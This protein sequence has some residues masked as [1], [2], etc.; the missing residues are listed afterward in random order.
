M[1][2]GSVQRGGVKD[3]MSGGL[4]GH[5]VSQAR[6]HSSR[7]SRTCSL[8]GLVAIVLVGVSLIASSLSVLRLGQSGLGPLKDSAPARSL[9]VHGVISI[10]GD[11]DFGSQASA[12]GWPGNG[13]LNN[14]Y[15][16]SGYDIDGLGYL[17][18]IRI[19][20]TT[21]YF[22]VRDCHLFNGM[23]GVFLYGV[24]N[25]MLA[26]NTCNDNLLYGIDGYNSAD[27][28]LR[29]NTCYSNHVGGIYLFFSDRNTVQDNFCYNNGWRSYDVFGMWCYGSNNTVSYNYCHHHNG[30]GITIQ[31]RGSVAL[32]NTCENNSEGIHAGVQSTA[33]NNNCRDNYV[34][35]QVWESTSLFN[36]C[37]N[38]RNGIELDGWYNTVEANICSDNTYNGIHSGPNVM[39]SVLGNN[40]CVANGVAGIFV[41]G[42]N[43]HPCLYNTLIGNDCSENGQ[44]GILMQWGSHNVLANNTCDNNTQIGL[45]IL[46]CTDEVVRGNIMHGDGVFV[47]G[48]L[49]QHWVLNSIDE[50]NLVNGIPV[51]FAKDVN[52]SAIPA[53]KGQYIIANSR[54]LD[55]SGLDVRNVSA[56]ISLGFCSSSTFRDCTSSNNTLYGIYISHCDRVVIMNSTFSDNTEHLPDYTLSGVYLDY[57]YGCTIA[58]NS[59]SRNDIGVTLEVSPSNVIANNTITHN[60]YVGMQFAVQSDYNEIRGN[61]FENNSGYAVRIP[62]ILHFPL[63]VGN[64]FHDNVFWYNNGATQVYDSSHIQ[65]YDFHGQYNH[66]NGSGR[67]NLWSDWQGPDSNGD[68][69]VD[70]PYVIV[71]YSTG[72]DYYPIAGAAG[73]EP[74]PEFPLA[75]PAIILVVVVVV[76]ASKGKMRRHLQE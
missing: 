66:W 6:S 50:T 70:N 20:N 7:S 47:E 16:I 12:E 4:T 52:G 56:G 73:G 22:E 59:I 42:T 72:R 58:N 67:G 31:G 49:L 44:D 2:G 18:T 51:Y 61:L 57:S 39:Y 23:T 36:N 11:A 40:T 46:Q 69:I 45:Y 9:I 28:S 10:E 13:H 35:I 76:L 26:N 64:T 1:Q 32:S 19:G 17:S 75:L 41:E 62:G 60:S 14:P 34:G 65:A 5:E 71:G 30:S 63:A 15:V 27:C 21:V 53:G 33:M 54:N 37:S 24:S 3:H 68:G 29:N 43:E 8:I 25:G 38:N 48:D 55:V 74:I